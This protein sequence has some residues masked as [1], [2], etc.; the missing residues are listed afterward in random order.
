[1][2]MLSTKMQRLHFKFQDT[3][4]YMKHREITGLSNVF[5]KKTQQQQKGKGEKKKTRAID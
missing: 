4:A 5:K 1:M 2:S 3:S